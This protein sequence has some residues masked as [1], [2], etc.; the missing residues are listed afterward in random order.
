MAWPT[1]LADSNAAPVLEEPR[2]DEDPGD[3]T[4]TDLT[5]ENGKS[6][7]IVSKKTLILIKNSYVGR[8]QFQRNRTCGDTHA[9][10]YRLWFRQKISRCRV[11]Y[12]TNP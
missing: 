9:Q 2:R 12:I 1:R 11:R 4:H 5:I 10:G 3:F 7:Y 8:I 6:Y